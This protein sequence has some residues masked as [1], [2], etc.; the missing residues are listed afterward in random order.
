MTGQTGSTL[1][2]LLVASAIMLTVTAAVFTMVNDATVRSPVWNDTVDL[3]QRGRV[4][5][6]AIRRV[7]MGAGA[8]IPS[9]HVP[10]IEPRRR[11]TF[12]ASSSALTIRTSPEGGAW[13]QTAGELAPGGST[14]SIVIHAGC[15]FSTIACGFTAGTDAAIVDDAGG[16]QLL[17][18]EAVAAPTT[19]AVADRVA[20][21][22]RTFPSG[23]PIG[24]IL[25]TSLYFDAASG[26]LRQQGPGEG[27]FPVVDSVGNVE[28]QYFGSGAAP[29]P[30]SSLV[31]GPLCGSGALAY[32]CDL[33][34][35][36]TVRA[37]LTIRSSRPPTND[38]AIVTD[39]SPRNA[40]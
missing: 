30:L 28:F 35:I 12:M 36:S 9:R 7:V 15:A 10:A 40:R 11:S 8:G 18:V 33:R 32:D 39:V 22:T 24:E 31:D 37:I 1:V 26:T 25:E 13:T 38:L 5:A 2:E 4:A 3:H 29:I 14:V 6:D 17:A 20:G 27:D 34:R 21:R 23:S 16:W 19:L